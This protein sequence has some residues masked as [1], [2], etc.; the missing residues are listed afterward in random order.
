MQA[1]DKHGSWRGAVRRTVIEGKRALL[2]RAAREEQPVGRVRSAPTSSASQPQAAVR[3]WLAEAVVARVVG[4]VAATSQLLNEG[5]LARAD[6]P[7]NN[8]SREGSL[9]D[10]LVEAGAVVA[11]CALA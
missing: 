8:N 7:V 2:L 1:N 9:T 5:G 3:S 6:I 4:D 11:W 10:E